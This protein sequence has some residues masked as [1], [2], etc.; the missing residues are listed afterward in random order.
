MATPVSL[1]EWFLNYWDEA[2]EGPVR[3]L[4]GTVGPGEVIF[5]PSGW[6]HMA[7]NLVVRQT[8]GPCS[9]AVEPLRQATVPFWMWLLLLIKK[10][11]H[12]FQSHDLCTG[13]SGHHTE[14][15]QLGKLEQGPEV[16]GGWL[17]RVG[18]WLCSA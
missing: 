15:L 5:V 18:L 3:P 11:Q 14:L 1:M 12:T 16:P 4:Q 8:R 6:W 10:P 7:I 2:M 13:D 17:S 9:V